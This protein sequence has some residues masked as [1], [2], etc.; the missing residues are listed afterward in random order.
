M[1]RQQLSREMWK[2]TAGLYW[3]SRVG[4]VCACAH[5]LL[6]GEVGITICLW[7]Q[8]CQSLALSLGGIHLMSLSLSVI[9]YN[10][11]EQMV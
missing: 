5:T 2:V 6:E 8:L 9:C 10:M 11:E 3:D 7:T 1:D 4:G